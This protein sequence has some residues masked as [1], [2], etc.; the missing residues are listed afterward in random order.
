M[1]NTTRRKLLPLVGALVAMAVAGSLGVT[2]ADHAPMRLAANE[3]ES[4]RAERTIPVKGVHIRLMDD[5]HCVKQVREIGAAID[6]AVAQDRGL[7]ILELGGARWRSDLLLELAELLRATRERLVD[8]DARTQ[9]TVTL[10]VVLEGREDREGGRGA[11]P[12]IGGGQATL[13]LIADAAVIRPDVRVVADLS[14]ELPT[15]ARPGDDWRPRSEGREAESEEE[16]AVPAASRSTLQAILASGCARRGVRVELTEL[17]P[18]PVRAA[19]WQSPDP[20]VG[21]H[22]LVRERAPEEGAEFEWGVLAGPAGG[23]ER[24]LRLSIGADVAEKVGLAV[25]SSAQPGRQLASLGIACANP[26]RVDIGAKLDDARL[27]VRELLSN[28]DREIRDVRADL[29]EAARFRAPEDRLRRRRAGERALQRSPGIEAAIARTEEVLL[30]HPELLVEPPPGSTPVGQTPERLP[31]EW[32]RTLQRL[33]D[34]AAELEAQ[35]RAL[36]EDRAV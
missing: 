7:V 24:S 12:V 36:A 20:W 32:R 6:R 34:D 3:P 29:R 15:P 22:A 9:R 33:R 26:E 23:D 31:G 27:L 2:R 18:R 21:G 8:V 28:V 1:P 14:S 16:D 30:E 19:W 13:A 35:A 4:E 5:L 25:E 11:S 10:L 17:L